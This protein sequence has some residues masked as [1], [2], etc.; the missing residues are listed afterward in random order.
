MYPTFQ[1][2]ILEHHNCQIYVSYTSNLGMV[3]IL[4]N[5]EILVAQ[6]SK[7][8]DEFYSATMSNQYFDSSTQDDNYKR[9]GATNNILTG[10]SNLEDADDHSTDD[11]DHGDHSTNGWKF[12][13]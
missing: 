4:I 11:H 3:S 1:N 7:Q 8:D 9:I 13:Q 5:L 6:E 12:E 2:K 10:T